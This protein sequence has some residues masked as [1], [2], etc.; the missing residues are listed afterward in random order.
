MVYAA[1]SWPGEG[2]TMNIVLFSSEGWSSNYWRIEDY[3]YVSA[4]PGEDI[5]FSIT[6]E[7]NGVI[8]GDYLHIVLPTYHKWTMLHADNEAF[9][10]LFTFEELDALVQA[11]PL[12]YSDLSPL[13]ELA[14]QNTFVG[15]FFLISNSMEVTAEYPGYTASIARD[16]EVLG[17]AFGRWAQNWSYEGAD[18]YNV[19]YPYGVITFPRMVWTS[20]RP[21]AGELEFWVRVKG[22]VIRRTVEWNGSKFTGPL[23]ERY[24]LMATDIGSFG[25]L[26]KTDDWRQ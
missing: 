25:Y 22:T 3:E 26:G 11:M 12:V 19:S 6:V 17:Y 21:E 14:E 13:N 8:D 10:K 9:E 24:S 20:P 18:G 2:S 1:T 16:G 15:C 23:P 4:Y 5:P 7:G